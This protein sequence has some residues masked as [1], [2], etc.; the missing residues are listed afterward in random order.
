MV[1]F[2]ILKKKIC[3]E[4]SKMS[5]ITIQKLWNASTVYELHDMMTLQLKM[6]IRQKNTC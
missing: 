5:V 4:I 6:M 3:T 1:F 2:I